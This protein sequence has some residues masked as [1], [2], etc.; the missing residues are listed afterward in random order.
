M[1]RLYL[2]LFYIL[3]AF[4]V[5]AQN[6]DSLVQRIVL[7]GDGGAL[8]ADGH[9]TVV[10]AVEKLVPL[11]KHT[12]VLYLGDNLYRHGL[13][14]DQYLSYKQAKAVLDSQANIADHFDGKVYFIPGN[15][16]WMNGAAGGY[17]AILRE[18]RYLDGLGKKNLKF[19]PEDGC[20]GPVEVDLGND[21][22]LVIMDSQW[23]IHQNDK[24]GIES[25]CKHKS[26][27]EV[28][29]ELK[30]IISQNQN[31]LILFAC[32]HPFKT[33]GAHGGYY[34]LKQH[35]FPFT[36]MRK[37]LY[38]PLPLLG[39]IY[40]IARSVFGTPQD[41][42]HPN[43]S[44]MVSMVDEVLKGHPHVIHVAGHEHAMEW[45]A[46]SNNN[47]IVSGSGCKTARVS[48]SRKSKFEASNLGFATLEIY[49]DK[50]VRCSFYGASPDSLRMLYSDKVLNYSRQPRPED[51]I[52][53]VP[54]HSFKD[55]VYVAASNKYGHPRGF[56]K[57]MLGQNY[58][59]EWT[60]P[61]N[62]KVFRLRTDNGGY[63]ITGSGGGF[64]TK[65][66]HLEDKNGIEYN[67][68][69]IDK[70]PRKVLPEGARSTFARDVVQD[71][72]SAA[73]PYAP[74]A[75]SYMADAAGIIHS[76]PVFYYVPD[77]TALG[78]YRPVFA[79]KVCMLE[80]KNGSMN[81]L[82]TRNTTKV[83]NKLIGE[84]DHFVDQEKVLQARL[85][86]MTIGDWD[87]HFDQWRW[88]VDDTGRGKL[89]Y[90]IPRDRDQAFFLS[91]GALMRL[92]SMRYLRWMR[93]FHEDYHKF[94]WLG[95][96][97]RN[98]DRIF[99][100]ELN[101]DQWQKGIRKFQDAE[102]DEVI[103]KAVQQ[104]PPQITAIDSGV[105]AHKLKSRRDQLTKAAMR[106]YRFIS[107]EVNV[108]GSNKDEFFTVKEEPGGI[109][110]Q[111]RAQEKD[112]SLL[113]Y[114]RLFDPKVT[115]EIR[116][117]GFNGN[118]NFFID[119]NV[120][121]RTRIRMIGGR[122]N[123]TFNVEGA[124]RSFIYDLS[125][126]N[127]PVISSRH[128]EV[129][130]S[131]NP[132]INDYNM[133]GYQYDYFRFPTISLGFN[134][135]D[136]ILLGAGISSRT[137]GFRKEPY[138]SDQ[139]LAFLYSIGWHAIQARYR[140]TFIGVQRKYDLVLN[141]DLEMPALRNF[142]GYGNNT[143]IAPGKDNTFYRARYKYASADV[144]LQRRM[145]G[146]G[147]LKL[148]VGPSAFHYWN[149][150][151]RN[152]D[153]VLEY[154][155]N[156]GLDS[157]S[158]YKSKTYLGGKVIADVNNL[159]SELFPTRGIAW[160][161]SFTALGD[162]TSGAHPY[163][164]LHTDMNIYA[165]LSDPAKL[166]AVLRAGGGHIFSENFEYFQ[167]ESVGQ[168]NFLRGFRK[169][170]FSGRSMAYGS[171]ELRIKITDV[172]SYFFPGTLGAVAFDDVARVWMDDELSKKWHNAFGGGLYY[173]PFNLFVLSA[174][175][176]HSR[177]ELLF[178][179]TLG[180][181]L[182]LTF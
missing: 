161:T 40:P 152:D 57:F 100:N 126:E 127:N 137:F 43:Y 128:T 56:R 34:T 143:E 15:H 108:L 22:L 166:I 9:H 53:A 37:N 104:M 59:D 73:H 47:Y 68:R 110:V 144:L 107:K 105:I 29:E 69:T 8:T 113:M 179:V 163:T 159:N 153:L 129:N 88:A 21:V 95:H 6:P 140:G 33:N 55:T 35:I 151:R 79:N 103:D 52:V 148:Q 46:D 115:K 50:T 181:K 44:N 124:A 14:D 28:V 54:L 120:R 162:L 49:K 32:H 71:M 169:N 12:T 138:K 94:L 133:Q 78:F 136:G 74:L 141:A 82:K 3:L 76:K 66:I 5:L 119:G 121:T 118:D 18:Q 131:S 11:D 155:Q 80:P 99:L 1:R 173:I 142:F 157:A 93:G 83:I 123:D 96:S 116:L 154:P 10:E 172:K 174:T 168:G 70:D 63:K 175:V 92:A 147:V 177:E 62:L 45:I 164:D 97:P 19:Q 24:P 139:R 64:Q 4:P 36:D 125:T 106:Y 39:S 132:L 81:D 158:V 167:A 117:Y 77:D 146:N 101:A 7:I 25:E 134:P 2:L 16:D 98:F 89:Y 42:K 171:A 150:T 60:Q 178:N 65:S 130:K 84:N 170:R 87:R 75:V 72:I 31:K 122:G 85:L 26:K 27:D 135:E 38:I 86:D 23:W 102:T 112:T 67:L 165:S 149:N 109:L 160:R 90:P 91:D 111:V 30:D 41:L 48:T 176:A 114:S 61:V 51:D 182:N 13:P 145:F 156:I 20:P 17:G 58:R 180:T